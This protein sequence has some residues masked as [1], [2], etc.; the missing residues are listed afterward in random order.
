MERDAVEKLKGKIYADKKRM[1][2]ESDIKVGDFVMIKDILSGHKLKYRFVDKKYQ[3]IDRKFA[4]LTL[5]DEQGV[6]C[7]R[8]VDHAKIWSNCERKEVVEKETEDIN[9]RSQRK[10]RRVQRPARYQDEDLLI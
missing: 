8:H 3:V 5:K 9:E 2:Q 4:V 1:A 10:K 6:E 7:K